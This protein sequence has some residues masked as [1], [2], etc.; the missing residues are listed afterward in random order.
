MAGINGVAIKRAIHTRLVAAPTLDGV[1]VDRHLDLSSSPNEYVYFGELEFDHR[2]VT[3]RGGGSRYPR[4]EIAYLYVYIEVWEYGGDID[5]VEDRAV[6]IGEVL[7]HVLAED[8]NLSGLPGVIYGGVAGGDLF[9]E[10]SVK[11]A[12][13]VTLVYRL[14]FESRLS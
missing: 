14:Q 9:P 12:V 2:Y 1:R 3:S 8:P 4:E 10:T 6:E 11:N 7:E 13:G 5:A